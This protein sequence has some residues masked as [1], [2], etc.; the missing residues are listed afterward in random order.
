MLNIVRFV[1]IVVGKSVYPSF[2]FGQ[3]AIGGRIKIGGIENG[4]EM[5]VYV[6][7]RARDVQCRLY[8]QQVYVTVTSVA[9]TEK[10]HL[11]SASSLLAHPKIPPQ[12]RHHHLR[13]ATMPKKTAPTTADI[14]LALEGVPT[15]AET[16]NMKQDSP[17]HQVRDE[18]ERRLHK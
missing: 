15:S 1:V 17:I 9:H 12:A 13:K 7:A 10:I 5:C 2:N 4:R 11:L 8:V 6:Y 14:V 18:E 16:V 3:G